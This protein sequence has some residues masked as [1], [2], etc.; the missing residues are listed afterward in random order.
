MV[1][2][3]RRPGNPDTR[4][5]IVAAAQAEFAEKGYDRTSMRGVAKAA[6]VDAA[7]VHHYFDSKDDLLLASMAVPIDPRRL[8]PEVVAAGGDHIGE[9]MVTRILTIWDDPEMQR[10]LVGLLRA[11]IA[12]EA[13]AELFREGLTRVVIA[14][15][16]EAF[17]R[18]SADGTEAKL[19]AERAASQI[20]GVIVTRYVFRLEPIASQSIEEVAAWAGPTI[21]RYLEGEVDHV[22]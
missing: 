11:A 21:Q 16:A 7:L 18:E 9:R 5:A 6:G 2:S 3:G 19:A 4:A 15:L 22:G 14:P 12:N 1:R 20:V 17:G 10:Q 13:A 8:I